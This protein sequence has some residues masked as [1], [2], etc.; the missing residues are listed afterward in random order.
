M[1]FLLAEPHD[2]GADGFPGLKFET[3]SPNGIGKEVFKAHHRL[4][5]GTFK[6]VE[7]DM[8]TSLT[9]SRT[10]RGSII[11]ETDEGRRPILIIAVPEDEEVAA[12]YF[13]TGA[14]PEE[15]RPGLSIDAVAEK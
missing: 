10:R 2:R 13:G 9:S 4:G 14:E 7:T 12:T 1:R 3:K 15:N 11:C 8:P 6:K 5:S